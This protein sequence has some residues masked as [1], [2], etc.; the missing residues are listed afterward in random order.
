MTPLRSLS[1]AILV[2][3]GVA[4]AALPGCSDDNATTPGTGGSGAGNSDDG[5]GS[6]TGGGE[7]GG[8]AVVTTP[9]CGGATEMSGTI[10]TV[11]PNLPAL[12]NVRAC[13]N[14]DAVS[15][16]LDP[17]DDAVD[18]RI[19]ALP[20]DD[21]IT[22]EGDGSVTIENALYR[23]A[24]GRSALYM[25]P[26]DPITNDNSAGGFTIVNG[27][28]V[29]FT[30]SEADS[31]LGYV[32]ATAGEDRL[33]V[34]VVGRGEA[35]LD[36]GR[37]VFNSTRP[38]RYTT[39]VAQRDAWVA[40]HGRDD[41]IAFYVPKDAGAGTHAVYEGPADDV[42]L[43][44]VDGPEATM[45]GGGATLFS[46]LD[47]PATDTLPL[48]RVFVSPYFLPQHDELVAGEAR[49]RKVRTEGDHPLTE[50][51]WSGL[52]ASTVLVI[53][54]LD[55]GCPYQGAL[56]PAHQDAYSEQ[57]GDETLPHETFF[58]IDELRAASPTGEVFVNGQFDDVPHP[59]AIARSLIQVAPQA[60]EGL[61]FYATFP[62]DADFRA[63][64]GEPEGNDYAKSFDSA[65]YTFSAYSTSRV[66]F[67]S[68]LGEFWTTYNDIASDT[69]GKIRLTPK[70]TG[71]LTADSYLHVTTEVDV[72]STDR[73][74]P[75]IL[76]SD[77]LAPVQENLE[78][79]TTLVV[80][81]KGFSPSFMQ[82]QVCDHRTWDVNNQCPMLATLSTDF[83]SPAPLPGERTG[84][85]NAVKIDVYVSTA[86]I[87][88]LLDDTPYSCTALPGKAEDGVSYSLPAGEVSITLGDVLYHS[89][90]D[91]ATGGGEV[92]G[93]SY[94]YYR[95]HMHLDARRHFDNF[96]FKSGSPP[97]EW[98]EA[99][100]PCVNPQ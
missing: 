37:A 5:G 38:K 16:K 19:Y 83:A 79:G 67:G 30:R 45:R 40:E 12:T 78:Q 53:E 73:R 6:Q 90:V 50:L 70:Q 66:Q 23:C 94:R 8:G 2:S 41:G 34:Y 28:V 1:T 14:G 84:A 95:E 61:D 80:Q 98:D 77:Q 60:P 96:G 46:V 97:P 74:Y 57:F 25:L 36:Q 43:R 21:A 58:T 72:V 99:L 87:Y 27:D 76:I 39:D 55:G 69:N 85:D 33:P 9:Q 88:V 10:K 31:T 4:S 86:R 22:V 7:M 92:Q 51:R 82:V 3:L 29:G 32:Y 24:G 65:D 49:F 63:G 17:L 54:A 71:E 56:S 89:G 48:K 75:Q 26:D 44:W 100:V 13:V 35:G 59:K 18:Y 62:E 52:T 47:A 42:R 68:M 20:A 91:F 11:L 93:N 64:F 81:P 15:V